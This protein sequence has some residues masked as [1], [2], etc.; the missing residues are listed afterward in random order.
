MTFDEMIQSDLDNGY[1]TDWSW[2]SESREQMLD[3]LDFY[4]DID[5]F[6]GI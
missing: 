5:L 4:F 2:T 3:E 1:V 6:Y